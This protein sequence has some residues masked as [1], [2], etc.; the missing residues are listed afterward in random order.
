MHHTLIRWHSCFVAGLVRPNF[1]VRPRPKLVFHEAE[2]LQHPCRMIMRHTKDPLS[3]C[4]LPVKF[5]E[6][7]FSTVRAQVLSSGEETGRPN[8]LRRLVLNLCGAAIK[9]DT[10]SWEMHSHKTPTRCPIRNKYII[11]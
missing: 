11:E 8:Y 3:V 1:Q 2:N 9:R 10:K 5:S 6:G 7:R 4:L